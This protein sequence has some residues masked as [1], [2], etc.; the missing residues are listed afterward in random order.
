MRWCCAAQRGLPGGGGPSVWGSV[1]PGWERGGKQALE[2]VCAGRALFHPFAYGCAQDRSVSPRWEKP[3]LTVPA[4]RQGGRGGTA[5]TRAPVTCD[6]AGGARSERPGRKAPAHP[7]RWGNATCPSATSGAGDHL[8]VVP[9]PPP[10]S[11]QWK[12]R[13]LVSCVPSPRLHSFNL[14]FMSSS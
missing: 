9:S 8:F 6:T 11:V 2:R 14:F 12:C 1:G 4:R 13:V 3:H 5:F 7:P 10:N